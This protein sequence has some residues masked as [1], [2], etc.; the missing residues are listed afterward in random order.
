[1]NYLSSFDG[2]LW[3]FL[4]LGALIFLQRLLHREIQAFFLLLTRKAGATQVLFA[5]VFFP[6]ILLHELS[7]FLM[8]KL[9][10]VRTGRFSIFPQALPNGRLQ[11]GYVETETGGT[12]RDALVGIAP[13]ITG[14]LFTAYVGIF[15]LNL[16]PLWDMFRSGNI[17]IFWGGL[18]EVLRTPDFW[19]WFYLAFVTS[20]T[21]LPSASD[22]HAWLPIGIFIG[23]VIIIA[24]LSGAGSWM[25]DNLAPPFNSF[26]HSLALVFGLSSFLHALLA[27]PFFTMHKLLAKIT[28]LDVK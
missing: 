25:L 28:G 24:I 7:H 9:L 27:L 17:D 6:G 18:R 1:M 3:L 19:L 15:R 12:L 14:V 10:G 20:S 5:L 13:L 4:T 21:M 16:L 8:A 11:L 22:R 2:L 23:T 26:L